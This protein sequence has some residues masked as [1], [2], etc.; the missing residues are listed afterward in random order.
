MTVVGQVREMLALGRNVPSGF[1]T[2]AHFGRWAR[3]VRDR[4]GSSSAFSRTRSPG[5]SGPYWTVPS[6]DLTP[7]ELAGIESIF[8]Q[9][10]A[11]EHAVRL[12]AELFGDVD[13]AATELF[14]DQ[15]LSP[16]GGSGS[17]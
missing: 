17:Y 10:S 12:A 15:R 3:E 7:G 8:R 9:A 4:R 6:Y 2:A 1:G 13:A 11:F 16:G 14:T 5:S